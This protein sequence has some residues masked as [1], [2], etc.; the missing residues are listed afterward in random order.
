MYASVAALPPTPFAR[1][2]TPNPSRP[3]VGVNR[4]LDPLRPH[5]ST[6]RNSLPR[7]W[8]FAMGIENRSRTTS[9]PAANCTFAGIIGGMAIGLERSSSPHSIYREPSVQTTRTGSIS[10]YPRH[11]MWS[12]LD[13]KV[14]NARPQ[15]SRRPALQVPGRGFRPVIVFGTRARPKEAGLSPKRVIMEAVWVLCKPNINNYLHKS[16]PEIQ[17]LNREQNRWLTSRIL[18]FR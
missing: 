11:P 13:P 17:E 14:P 6:R 12:S 10:S 7:C 15:A 8:Y 1:R 5:N 2:T 16:P 4:P 9:L 3:P 18:N